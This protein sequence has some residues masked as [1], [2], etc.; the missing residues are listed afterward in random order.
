MGGPQGT[1]VRSHDVYVGLQHCVSSPGVRYTDLPRPRATLNPVTSAECT[2]RRPGE[3]D[4]T[5]VRVKCVGGRLRI[6]VFVAVQR[7]KRSGST[8]SQDI[9]RY[10]RSCAEKEELCLL[11]KL[12]GGVWSA[13]CYRMFMRDT[14]RPRSCGCIQQIDVAPTETIFLPFVFCIT[15]I[16]CTI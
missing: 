16:V 8:H 12:M 5:G 13:L 1:Y 11:G 3:G 6:R 4:D 9:L 2:V 14:A 15:D 7:T 10:T